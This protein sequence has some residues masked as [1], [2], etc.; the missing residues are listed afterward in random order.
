MRTETRKA[1]PTA[2]RLARWL[3]PLPGPLRRSLTF[4]SGT[5]FALCHRLPLVT[6]FCD[7]QA[8]WQNGGV[9]NGMERL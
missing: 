2:A 9:E 8:P 6:Y 3:E 5:E 1:D 7:P 4:D